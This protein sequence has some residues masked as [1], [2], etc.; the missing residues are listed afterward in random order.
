MSADALVRGPDEETKLPLEAVSQFGRD[1]KKAAK[2]VLD[3]LI[4]KHQAKRWTGAG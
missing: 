4:L 2:D 3:A 1:V